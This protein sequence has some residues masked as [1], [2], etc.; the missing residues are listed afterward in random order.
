[1]G[2]TSSSHDLQLRGRETCESPGCHTDRVHYPVRN[3]GSPRVH[4]TQVP[5]R[6]LRGRLET[7][8]NGCIQVKGCKHR[9]KDHYK[10]KL[11]R[12]ARII[13][14]IYHGLDLNDPSQQANHKNCCHNPLCIR[15]SHLYVGTQSENR[16]D[17][18]D[19]G[20]AKVR[21]KT[22]LTKEE[23]DLI[24]SQYQSHSRG[25]YSGRSLAKSFGVSTRIISIIVNGKPHYSE[26]HGPRH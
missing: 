9:P 26:R 24:K 12:T 23:Y 7:T 21:G 2:P 14:A 4:Q 15:P 19:R 17:E 22:P 18:L 11:E 20:T 8:P 10:G 1:M 16:F 13:A 25:Q 3:W 5:M 6:S